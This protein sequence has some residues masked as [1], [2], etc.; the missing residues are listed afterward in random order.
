MTKL[1]NKLDSKAAPSESVQLSMLGAAL[2]SGT[3]SKGIERDI[4]PLGRVHV[5]LVGMRD[6]QRIEAE[7]VAACERLNISQDSVAFTHAF[8]AEKALRWLSL[9]LRDPD[10]PSKPYGSLEE[11]ERVDVDAITQLWLAY[12]DVRDMLQPEVIELDAATSATIGA[13]IAQK[14]SALLRSFG[15]HILVSYML[16]SGAPLP[17]SQT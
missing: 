5:A 11:W 17:T 6:A 12:G 16:S 14:K 1:G 7:C 13:A 15:T 4:A 9:A 8:E 3:I 2:S 10:D